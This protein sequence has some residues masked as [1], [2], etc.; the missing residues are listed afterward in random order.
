MHIVSLSAFWHCNFGVTERHS[1]LWQYVHQGFFKVH[2]KVKRKW[3]LLYKS[4]VGLRPRSDLLFD[5][6]LAVV[7]AIVT[8]VSWHRYVQ[9]QTRPIVTAVAWSVCWARAS[10]VLK[11]M[12]PTCRLGCGVVR[13]E[14]PC[15]R[16]SDGTKVRRY[17]WQSAGPWAGHFQC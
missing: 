11:R 16:L 1:D 5:S 2:V 12:R 17:N 3:W 13:S 4:Y 14:K 9:H 8:V 15:I 7:I 10:A 6:S